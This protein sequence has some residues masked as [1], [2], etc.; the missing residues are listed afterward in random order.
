MPLQPDLRDRLIDH[1]LRV[2]RATIKGTVLVAVLQGT[3]MAIRDRAVSRV[4]AAIDKAEQDPLA[5]F[6]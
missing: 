4:N 5:E 2:V 1:F 3:M 6:Q